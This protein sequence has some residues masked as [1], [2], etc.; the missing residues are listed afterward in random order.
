[1]RMRL[2]EEEKKAKQKI[3]RQKYYQAH[4]EEHN[5]LV[6]EWRKNNPESVKKSSK[7]YRDT[8]KEQIRERYT[9]EPYLKKQRTRKQKKN[10]QSIENCDTDIYRKNWTDEEVQ[11]LIDNYQSMTIPELSEKMGRTIMAIER[12]RNKLGLRKEQ[13]NE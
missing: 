13:K 5:E 1:M 7:K 11:Y 4:K 8:H 2:S 9:S 6:R 12:K 10:L 3:A